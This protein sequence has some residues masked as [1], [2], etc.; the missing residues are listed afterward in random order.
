MPIYEPLLNDF[1]DL[2]IRSIGKFIGLSILIIVVI[3]FAVMIISFMGIIP[4]TREVQVNVSVGIISISL[5]AWVV[6]SIYRQYSKKDEE[7]RQHIKR[8][9][10]I[11]GV[12]ITAILMLFGIVY[13]V[14]EILLSP[15]VADTGLR[16]GIAIVVILVIALFYIVLFW[17]KPKNPFARWISR[18]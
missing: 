18:R 13:V 12:A 7:S 15:I 10:K 4:R 1:N 11:I 17:K 8:N 2:P 5:V 16:I 3:T 14:I 6:F 9:A